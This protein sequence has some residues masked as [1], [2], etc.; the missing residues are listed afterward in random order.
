MAAMLDLDRPYE[1][2]GLYDVTADPLLPTDV[3][4]R[5]KLILDAAPHLKRA[6]VARELQAIGVGV[7]AAADPEEYAAE[8][9][10]EGAATIDPDTLTEIAEEAAEALESREPAEMRAALR[11]IAGLASGEL[12]ELPDDD[13][14]TEEV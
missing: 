12:P 2:L 14:P 6:D 4:G 10:S 5:A 13:E 3:P 9:A 11:E 8:V 1:E 7:P